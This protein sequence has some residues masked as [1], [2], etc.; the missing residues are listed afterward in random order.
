MICG[1]GG[2]SGLTVL[3]IARL[4]GETPVVD[5]RSTSQTTVADARAFK[6]M[7]A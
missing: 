3:D 2:D 7:P 6:E 5:L 4:H 1:V